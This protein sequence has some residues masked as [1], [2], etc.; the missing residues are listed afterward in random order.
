MGQKTDTRIV[1]ETAKILG[2]YPKQVRR[3]IE[4]GELP[5][6]NKSANTP[7]APFV[8]P[9][10]SIEAYRLK[11]QAKLEKKRAAQSTD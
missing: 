10:K 7:N 5:G 1:S 9:L 2:T 4:R 11:H 3:L 6:A 8:I